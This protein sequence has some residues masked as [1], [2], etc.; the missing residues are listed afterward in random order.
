MSE[1]KR[2]A[3][4]YT[5]RFKVADFT[6]GKFD[7]KVEIG[8]T[9]ADLLKQEYWS[10]VSEL[11]TPYSEITVRCDDGTFYAKY[12]VLDCGRGWAKV[13]ELNW[14]NLTTTDVAQT[15]SIA[16]TLEDFD[17]IWKGGSRKHII[18][19]KSD[20]VVLHEGLQRKEAAQ[21]WLKDSLE[22][23]VTS[24]VPEPQ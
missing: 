8:T 1:Q 10:H 17:I 19:R 3:R 12:L 5:D 7:A 20:Q 21:D 15:Q 22:K 6:L 18:Q 9:R 23:R 14:W 11:M 2:D 4:I 24:T 16:G 13:Q